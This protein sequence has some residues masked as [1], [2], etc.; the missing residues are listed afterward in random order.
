VE[1]T[2]GSVTDMNE[3]QGGDEGD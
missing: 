2:H 1:V 3:K